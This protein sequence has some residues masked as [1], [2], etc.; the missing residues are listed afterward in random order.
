MTLERDHISR[1]GLR[2]GHQRPWPGLSQSTPTAGR[3]CTSPRRRAK[4][5]ASLDIEL[6]VVVYKIG[7]IW[8]FIW[9]IISL[10]ILHTTGV[11]G[12]YLALAWNLET[13]G[14]VSSYFHRYIT[15]SQPTNN[16]VLLRTP[17]SR[18]SPF[19]NTVSRRN[20]WTLRLK[21]TAL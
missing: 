1:V 6:Y 3:S 7:K 17:L 5:S 15:N 4:T 18:M 11:M 19:K 21:Y 8:T 2:T 12:R 20:S 14:S 16:G 10:Q 9:K 13:L